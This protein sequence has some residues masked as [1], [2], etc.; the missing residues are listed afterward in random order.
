MTLRELIADAGFDPSEL[1]WRS[2]TARPAGPDAAEAW[3]DIRGLAY[4]SESV[5][6]GTL[7][8]CVPGFKVDGHEF[9][10]EA[11]ERGAVALVC[12]RALDVDVP[13]LV[14]PGVRAAMPSIAAAFHGHPTREL[15]VVG[16]TGTNGKTTTTF[17]LREI[18]E[19]SGIQ[20][21]LLGTVQSVVGGEVEAVERTTPEAIDLQQSFRRMVESG[22]A[23][24]VM[25][26]SSHALELRR[27]DSIDF[28]CAVFTN[29]H[30]ITSTSTTR[31][32]PISRRSGGCSRLPACRSVPS[33]TSTT[34]G[35]GD[36]RPSLPAAR[37]GW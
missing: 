15:K 13:Q 7:F 9:A 4:R 20:T 34:N 3:P 35:E 18:L 24:C 6:P 32:R 19:A 31:S 2:A 14:V 1:I 26:V 21:A 12:E 23:A 8:F 10:A 29:L 22:D 28:D 17:L 36:W 11:I 33:S 16:V 27:A 5:A 37:R 30:S 25:E